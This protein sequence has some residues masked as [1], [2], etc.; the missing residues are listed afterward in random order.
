LAINSR[1]SEGSP[2]NSPSREELENF[3]EKDTTAESN[4][5]NTQKFNKDNSPFHSR[6]QSDI[7]IGQGLETSLS[8]QNSNKAMVI[9]PIQE[10]YSK[11][12]LNETPNE[13]EWITKEA[14]KFMKKSP[15]TFEIYSTMNNRKLS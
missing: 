5:M 11:H 15:K 3:L 8:L 6:H 12:T 9:Q 14:K 2:S 4:H 13:S 10:C 1:S 7:L